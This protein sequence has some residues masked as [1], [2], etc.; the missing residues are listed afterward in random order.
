MAVATSMAAAGCC[1]SRV[2]F[3]ANS[4]SNELLP[5]LLA[6]FILKPRSKNK[7]YGHKVELFSYKLVMLEKLKFPI[8]CTFSE[9]FNLQFILDTIC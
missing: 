9:Q 7:N 6:S 3:D 1:G 4:F 5:E 2:S 8:C